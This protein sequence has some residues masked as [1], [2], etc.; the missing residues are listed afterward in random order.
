[1]SVSGS[2]EKFGGDNNRATRMNEKGDQKW[3]VQN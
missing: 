2:H 1:M 3:S